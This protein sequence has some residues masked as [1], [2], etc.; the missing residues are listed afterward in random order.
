MAK[1]QNHNST[2]ASEKREPLWQRALFWLGEFGILL[3]LWMLFVSKPAMDELV[4]GIFAAAIAATASDVVRGR[5]LARFYP[6]FKDI[7][8][9]IRIPWYI[10]S[11]TA[12]ISQVLV[13]QLLA[14]KPAESL[15]QAVRFDCGTDD[16]QEASERR[17]LAI[18]YTTITPNFVVIGIQQRPEA[19]IYH[20]L[21][22]SGVL[23][24]TKKLGAQP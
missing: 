7:L 3:G 21:K 20:Q 23:E 9:A 16:E 5:N 17:A 4:V 11:G 22:K 10:F 24:M 6:H 19:M 1:Q 14:G 8:Q 12:E 13:R 15:I 2:T 18:A